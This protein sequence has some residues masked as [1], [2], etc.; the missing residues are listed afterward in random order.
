M[1]QPTLETLLTETPL[2]RAERRYRESM[3]S[4]VSE[5]TR[6]IAATEYVA[7]LENALHGSAV[8]A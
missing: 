5:W 1:R 8:A 6:W 4:G 3:E 2:E 7:Q